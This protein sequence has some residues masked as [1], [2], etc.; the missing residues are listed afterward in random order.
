MCLEY[1]VGLKK[2]ADNVKRNQTRK[3]T[4]FPEKLKTSQPIGKFFYAD[5]LCI[6]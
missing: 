1:Q 3:R 4:K 5:D 6:I 2:K